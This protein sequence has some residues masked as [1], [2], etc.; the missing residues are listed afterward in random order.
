MAEYKLA[1]FQ[2]GTAGPRAGVV[3]GDRIVAASS[4]ITAAGIDTNSVLGLLAAWEQSHPLLAAAAAN[5]GPA[6][7]KAIADVTL[8]API[9]YPAAVFCAGANYWDHAKEMSAAAAARLGV[10]EKPLIKPKDPFFFIKTGAHSI[11]APGAP[12]RLHPLS[13]QVD[14]EAEA[15][16]VIGRPARNVPVGR[17]FDYVAGYLNVND[18]SARDL[19]VQPDRAGGPMGMDWFS[20]KCFEDACPMGPFLVPAAFVPNPSDMT[21]KLWVNGVQKQNSNT[22]ELIHGI[23][24]QISYLSHRVTLRPGDVIATGTPAG[25]G[26]GRGEFLKAG[27]EVRVEVGPCGSLVNPVVAPEQTAGA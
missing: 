4:L 26:A 15:G 1:T 20:Q 9:L 6:D 21:V 16:V 10:E 18:V 11:I 23:A 24:E 27:D 14:W 13:R 5:I 2:D 19:S 25:V 12:I 22:S 8:L 17:A 7:G 3:T